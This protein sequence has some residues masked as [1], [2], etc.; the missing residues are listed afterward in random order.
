MSFLLPSWRLSSLFFLLRERQ[1]SINMRKSSPWRPMRREARPDPWQA[2]IMATVLGITLIVMVVLFMYRTIPER[3]PPE[4]EI[5]G[6]TTLEGKRKRK[7]EEINFP[8]GHIQHLPPT[9]LS[10]Q[11]MENWHKFANHFQCE[12]KD[13]HYMQIQRDLYPFGIPDH[14]KARV[15]RSS[16]EGDAEFA[17]RKGITKSMVDRGFRHL[18]DTIRYMVINGSVHTD[19][20]VPTLSMI[21]AS[22]IQN[23][24]RQR[25]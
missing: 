18:K 4:F 21:S 19:I 5:N 9:F 12:A 8:Q 17:S 15:S 22:N 11:D 3:F 16:W 7:P 23:Q 10:S 25:I 14:V 1:K 20:K 13:E 24:S 6:M 2:M